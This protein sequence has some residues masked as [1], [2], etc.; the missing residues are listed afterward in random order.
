RPRARWPSQ[1]AKGALQV[2]T[3][4]WPFVQTPVAF[5]TVQ[6]SPFALLAQAAS[7]KVQ[8]PFTHVA[9]AGQVIPQ[10]PQFAELVKMLVSQ[11]SARVPL[12]LANPALH[13]PT[14]VRP[15]PLTVHTPLPLVNEQT[16]PAVF[17]AQAAS[18]ATVHTPFAHT[19]D[20][21]CVPQ[22]PQL[23]GSVVVLTQLPP[24][25]VWPGGQV[26]VHWPLTQ[27]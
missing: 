3:R 17:P 11:P 12:Q 26:V 14:H 18:D 7:G 4:H 9:P 15:P 5:V 27:T 24:Q 10:P 25:N 22:V 1:S 8:A 21:Q 19:P 16:S 23:F 6:T 20:A 13:V 2:A